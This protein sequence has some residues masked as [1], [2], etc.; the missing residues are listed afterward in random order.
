MDTIK[1]FPKKVR[2]SV[3]DFRKIAGK[4]YP[5][6]RQQHGTEPGRRTVYE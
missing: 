5:T 2:E 6:T 1:S 4:I 3:L